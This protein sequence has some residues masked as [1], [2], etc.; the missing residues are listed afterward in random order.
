MRVALGA[1][2]NKTDRNDT[3]GIARGK[4]R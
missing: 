3:R 1:Q 4:N 2:I